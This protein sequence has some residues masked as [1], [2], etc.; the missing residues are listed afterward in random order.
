MCS[1]DEKHIPRAPPKGNYDFLGWTNLHVSGHYHAINVLLFWINRGQRKN[2]SSSKLTSPKLFI[3]WRHRHNIVLKI[4]IT[5]GTRL[6]LHRYIVHILQPAIWTADAI[7][8]SDHIYVTRNERYEFVWRFSSIL[9]T[10]WILNLCVICCTT[11]EKF[12]YQ[13]WHYRF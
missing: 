11:N 5:L 2:R 4:R 8:N 1:P 3:W 10:F 12:A 6:I 9:S 7:R 13:I